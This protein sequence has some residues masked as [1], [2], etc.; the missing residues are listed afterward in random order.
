MAF[1]QV[2]C[3]PPGG[4]GG[5]LAGEPLTAGRG[6]AVFLAGV[7]LPPKPPA[8]L[9]RGGGELLTYS[10]GIPCGGGWLGGWV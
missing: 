10:P 8:V 9:E 1:G 4:P 5:F 3:S 2:S 7:L 6:P